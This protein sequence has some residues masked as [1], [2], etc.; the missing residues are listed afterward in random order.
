MPLA[1]RPG[2]AHGHAV[3]WQGV[4]PPTVVSGASLPS[5]GWAGGREGPAALHVAPGWGLARYPSLGGALE[6]PRA[7]GRLRVLASVT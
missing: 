4:R 3:A 5:P 6:G 2:E 1:A 7:W